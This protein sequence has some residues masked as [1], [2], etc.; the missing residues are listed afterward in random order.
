MQ[1]SLTVIILTKNE[2]QNLPLC[3]RSLAGIAER[4]VVVDS[5][6]DDK[7]VEVATNLGCDVYQNPFVNYATQSNWAIEQTNI[8]TDWI[9]RLDADEQLLP[10]DSAKIA[11][12]LATTSDPEITGFSLNR[13]IYFLGRWIRHGGMYPISLLRIFRR[14]CGSVEQREMDEHTI[15]THGNSLALPC[16]IVHQDFKDLSFWSNKHVWYSGREVKDYYTMMD[17]TEL[18]TVKLD[19]KTAMKRGLK[20]NLYYR[21]PLLMRSTL[22]FCYRYYFQLGFLDGPEGK[23]YHFLQAYW[24]RFLVDAMIYERKWREKDSL[25]ITNDPT[26]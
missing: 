4:I 21:L 3:I 12:V 5:L 17:H 1:V 23:I 26:G 6:S 8:T 9:F 14:G 20:H 25:S 7:T 11:E 19:A 13:R 16:D 24:Y 10:G 2:E 15:L 22:Y 18:P